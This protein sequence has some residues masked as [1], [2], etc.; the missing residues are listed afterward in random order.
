MRFACIRIDHL[1]TRLEASLQPELSSQPLVVLRAWDEHVLDASPDAA[2]SGVHPGDSHRRVEQLCPQAVVLPARETLY[3]SHHESLKAILADFADRVET[4]ALGEL[5][6]ELGALARTFPSEQALAEQIVAQAHQAV[7][8]MPVAGIAANK[9]TAMQ[10]ARQASL[11]TNHVLV[12]TKGDER[13]FLSSLPL[14][15][16]PDPLIEL[17]RRLH[18]FGITTLGGF[19]DLPHAAVVMQFGAECGLFHDLARGIDPRPLSPESPPP[20]LNR[21]LMLAEPLLDRRQVLAVVEHLAGRL[22][23]E[24][25]KSGHHAMALSLTVSTADTQGDVS[26]RE[27]LYPTQTTGTTVKPPSSNVQLL[28]RTAGRLLGNLK[29][30]SGVTGLA[31]SAYPLR[32]WHVGARQMTLLD[33]PVQPRLARLREVLR[34]LQQRFGEAVIRLASV[35]GPP[36]PLSIDV[37]LRPDGAPMWLRWGGWAR[38]VDQV[39]EFWREQHNWWD[40]PVARDYYQVEVNGE[41]VFTVFCDGKGRWFLDRRRG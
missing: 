22:A 10:A 27:P 3:Q 21:S 40:Q 33:E 35:I 30:S 29:L 34:N 24:L 13:R 8:L 15:V 9:F 32:E 12:V 39:Y 7:H 18:L 25:D 16:L 11:E 17:L 6:I 26:G 2:A 1:P 4:A 31:L 36:L 14:T 20:I 41:V 28:R 37:G 5:Y 23:R 38:L 19:A